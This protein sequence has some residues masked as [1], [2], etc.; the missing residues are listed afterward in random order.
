MVDHLAARGQLTE[1]EELR[2]RSYLERNED[3]WPGEPAIEAGAQLYLDDLSVSYLRTTGLLHKLHAAGLTA[4]VSEREVQEARDLIELESRAEAIEAVIEKIRASLSCGIAS[5]AVL[6][7]RIFSDDE[8]K[9]HPNIAVIQ[10]APSVDAIISDDR[11]MNQHRTMDH[12]GG[13][14]SIWTSLD[15]LDKMRADGD[16]TSDE[17]W[18]HRTTMRQC[19][20]ALLPSD[21]EE[22]SDLI[23]RAPVRDGAVGET[24][25]L[26][27]YR[28]NLRL[29]QLRGWLNLPREAH[30]LN[31]LVSDIVA[32]ICTQWRDDVADEIARAR[33]RWLLRCADMRNW[34]GA[35]SDGD[36]LNLARFG[37]AVAINSLLMSRFGVPSKD[38]AERMD[39]WL[40]D[41]VVTKLQSEEP[42]I[43]AW[44]IDSLRLIVSQRAVH[45]AGND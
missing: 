1:Q 25:E 26:R 3:R 36:G 2:A 21:R 16:L 18:Q 31:K 34:A 33:S 29:A 4:S 17:L 40:R 38:S 14:A 12:E 6:V 8:D 23:E 43:Y 32:T 15:L 19:G 42:A 44:L 45:A 9:S 10:L 5:G 28:E 20:L 37:M 35:I 11:Y 39:A 24:G 22:L 30:W 27:A 41:E 13:S 7:D